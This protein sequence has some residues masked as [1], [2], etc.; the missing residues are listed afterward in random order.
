MNC[1]MKYNE[2]WKSYKSYGF[3]FTNV[4]VYTVC[5]VRSTFFFLSFFPYL[6]FPSFSLSV[7]CNIRTFLVKFM[8]MNLALGFHPIT[9][10]DDD[11]GL[12][13]DRNHNSKSIYLMRFR[14]G[15]RDKNTCFYT[16]FR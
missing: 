12:V 10:D 2:H 14:I 8:S 6:F 11:D 9:Y 7:H 4:S 5:A 1:S 3:F 15:L 13:V 16:H